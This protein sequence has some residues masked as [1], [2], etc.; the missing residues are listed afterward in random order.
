MNDNSINNMSKT[1]LGV[2]EVKQARIP[3]SHLYAPLTASLI[4]LGGTFTLFLVVGQTTLVSNMFDLASFV[5]LTLTALAT[6]YFLKIRSYRGAR[7][8]V[9][10]SISVEETR[11]AERWVTISAV[12]FAMYGLALLLAY[13]ATEI[14]DV[15]NAVIHPGNA[16]FA[17][18][19]IY[20][21]EQAAGGSNLPIQ[22][23]TLFSILYT[24]LVPLTIVY[25]KH[26]H[27]SVRY[28]AYLGAAIYASFFFFI[29][30]L[31]GLGDLLVFGFASH[32]VV[33]LGLWPRKSGKTI[34]KRA[35]VGIVV[36]LSGIFVGY[37]AFNQSQRLTHSGIASRF[38]P[39]PIIASLT[40]DNF[41]RGIA[42]VAFYPTHGYLG[43]SYNLETPFVWSEGRGSSRAL[44]SYWTQYIGGKSGYE[45]TYPARTEMRTGWLG[46]RYWATA[47]PWFASD[48]SFPGTIALMGVIGWFLARTWFEAAFGRSRLALLLFCQFALLIVYLPANNQIGT[49]RTSLIAFVCLV[50]LYT[51]NRLTSIRKPR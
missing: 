12:Y 21:L 2:L 49:S 29:G 27:R 41:A 17:K 47:Y 16:Y 6:G 5:S 23:L 10:E 28:M 51:A 40:G 26:L 38:E 37:M 48:L 11:T 1:T 25:G 33:A 32:M 15:V 35:T 18:F 22:I 31:K 8:L 20:D 36:L 3:V 24:P 43:L 45:S 13:G 14:S 44:D 50:L 7:Q 39:N 4:Y 9:K 19:H 46:L 42:V 30:T 34:S